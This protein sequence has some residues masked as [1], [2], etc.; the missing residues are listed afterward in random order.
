M[1]TL[2]S[3]LYDV[4]RANCIKE[5]KEGSKEAFLIQVESEFFKCETYE[6]AILYSFSNEI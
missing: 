1:T 5:V 4:H 6:N 3:V 2:D